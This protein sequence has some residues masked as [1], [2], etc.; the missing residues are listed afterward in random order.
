MRVTQHE[1]TLVPWSNKERASTIPPLPV[2][3][4]HPLLSHYFHSPHP[5]TSLLTPRPPPSLATMH[6]LPTLFLLFLLAVFTQ[7]HD[8]TRRQTAAPCTVYTATTSAMTN[9]SGN[10]SVRRRIVYET[11]KRLPAGTYDQAMFSWGL[12]WGDAKAGIYILTF[13]TPS[14]LLFVT[15]LSRYVLTSTDCK[16]FVGNL[17]V[18]YHGTVVRGGAYVVESDEWLGGK[19]DAAHECLMGR[20]TDMLV[21]ELGCEV[22]DTLDGGIV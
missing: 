13:S 7:A 3:I 9:L 10:A 6:L 5:T 15:R 21:R 2:P 12:R 11:T 4:P 16:A 1:P 14:W 17:N 22:S 18:Y 19:G 8:I 20:F